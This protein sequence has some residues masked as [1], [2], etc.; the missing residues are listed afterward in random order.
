MKK[1]LSLIIAVV[2]MA[3]LCISATATS[4]FDRLFVNEN[5]LGGT[6]VGAPEVHIN[7]GDSL[8]I[9]GW[10]ID[11]N[12]GSP[13]KEVVYTID[14]GEDIHC[15]DNYRDRPGLCSIIGVENTELDSHA[16]I[17]RDDS[18][19]E[20]T[21]INELS[22]GTY[23]IAIYVIYENGR[24]DLFGDGMGYTYSLH[25]GRFTLVVGEGEEVPEDEKNSAVWMNIEQFNQSWDTIYIDGVSQMELGWGSD[26]AAYE[27]VANNPIYITSEQTIMVRGWA[28]LRDEY[29]GDAK[30]A[31]YG[32]KINLGEAVYN[33]DFSV[34]AEDPVIWAG[35]DS[36]YC[37]TVPVAGITEKSLITIVARDENYV[38][39]DMFEFSINGYMERDH[40]FNTDNRLRI[41][42]DT[43][44][45]LPGDEIEYKIRLINNEEI[46]SCVLEVT[47]DERLQLLDAWYDICDENRDLTSKPDGS[48]SDVGSGF[49]FNWLKASGAVYG[50]A[51]FVTL[52]FKVSD[53][54]R[55]TEFL[56]VDLYVSDPDDIFANEGG[57]D[58]KDIPFVTI[59]GGVNV[60]KEE[61]PVVEIDYSKTNVVIS[62]G[63]EHMYVDGGNY[64]DVYVSLRNIYKLRSIRAVLR[65]SDKLTLVDAEYLLPTNRSTMWNEPEYDSFGAPDWKSVDGEFCFNWVN[66]EEDV[67]IDGDCDFVRLTFR[68][69]PSITE[70]EFLPITAEIDP[71]DFLSGKNRQIHFNLI[72]GGI[73]AIAPKFRPG[74]VNCDGRIN[75]I[76]VVYLFRFVSDKDVEIN[77]L[78][79]DVNLDGQVNNLDVVELFRMSSSLYR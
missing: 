8:Y 73:D 79:A 48:W 56:P 37:V 17:G 10:A 74:D 67:V 4:S 45:A 12:D 18:A 14:D 70:D 19:F 40:S 3:A 6:D 49:I 69:S 34:E 29:A 58:Y 41:V 15:A 28:G 62:G 7:P 20:L 23:E 43:V 11:T 25:N 16:G 39:Y 53:D 52:R 42:A 27:K 64:V 22:A 26:G 55:S 36:R 44:D 66:V 35:G 59:N 77:E 32:Y 47:W 72:N 30:I 75:N 60:Y 38:E 9:L 61:R 31:A 51:D 33:A 65:W 57:N 63:T 1:V 24:R 21:G 2:M 5:T 78:N 50:D 68:V 46:S 54:I 13:L 71:I 76:D